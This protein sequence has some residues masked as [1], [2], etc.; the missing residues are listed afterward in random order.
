ME[1]TGNCFDEAKQAFLERSERLVWET[2]WRKGVMFLRGRADTR[3]R[4]RLDELVS[5]RSSRFFL[6]PWWCFSSFHSH[7]FLAD[8]VWSIT[9]KNVWKNNTGGGGRDEGDLSE[10]RWVT[11]IIV[12]A[13]NVIVGEKNVFFTPNVGSNSSWYILL[14]M[15]ITIT[16]SMLPLFLLLQIWTIMGL[17]MILSLAS[18]LKKLDTP[19]LATWS[20]RRSRNWTATRTTWSASMSSWWYVKAD[21]CLF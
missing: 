2:W 14:Q 1:A 8:H 13:F 12:I 21:T 19:C 17:L 11:Q 9:E 20:E 10:N 15:I 6:R 18:S 7:L 16:P 3:G 4:R 5:A